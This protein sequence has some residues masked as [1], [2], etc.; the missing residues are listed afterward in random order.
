MKTKYIYTNR[1]VFFAMDTP[2]AG[3][4]KPVAIIT[5]NGDIKKA[6]DRYIMKLAGK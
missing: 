6:V 4:M 2:K 3:K 5:S 1:D